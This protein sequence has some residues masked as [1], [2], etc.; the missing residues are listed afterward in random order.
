MDTF[1]EAKNNLE[2]TNERGVLFPPPGVYPRIFTKTRL[3]YNR[4][5]TIPY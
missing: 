2:Q 1:T 3:K 4:K 5:G